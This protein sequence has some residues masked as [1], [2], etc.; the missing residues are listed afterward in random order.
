MKLK[1]IL[2]ICTTVCCI[3]IGCTPRNQND[4]D[5]IHINLRGSFPEREMRLE[6]IAEIDFLQLE[7]HDDFLFRGFPQVITSDKIIIANPFSGD[8]LIF[9]RDGSPVSRFNRQGGGPE[10]FSQLRGIVFD[11]VA[12]EIFVLTVDRI[13]VYSLTGKFIRRVSLPEGASVRE[14]VSY[15]SESL[16]LFGRDFVRND[17][18]NVCPLSSFTIISKKDGSVVTT[19]DMPPVEIIEGVT[20]L[21]ASSRGY[22]IFGTTP[23]VRHNDGFLLNIHATDTV[24]LYRDRELIPFLTRTPRLRS[25]NSP[26]ILRNFFEA[27]N[28]QFFD[29]QTINRCGDFSGAHLMRDKRTGAVYR[30]RII[31]DDF[32]GRSVVIHSDM[33]KCS[34]IGLLV[35]DLIELKNAND[36]S[37]LSGR[38]KELVNNSEEDG[39]NIFMLL[40]FK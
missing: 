35:L 4:S 14:M 37:R 9:S 29:T 26:V 5:L 7:T 31:F 33:V 32:R 2:L 16:L 3:F 20:V 22:T 21:M 13:M 1:T 23:I 8:I 15:D 27:G 34:G 6:K 40:H 10:E 17:E 11:G 30:Q 18:R 19:I 12:D 28:F 38:L 24:F 25:M 39:N 36:E